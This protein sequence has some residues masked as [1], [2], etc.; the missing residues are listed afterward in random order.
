M[1]HVNMALYEAGDVISDYAL[2]PEEQC[3]FKHSHITMNLEAL[4]VMRPTEQWDATGM[5]IYESDICTSSR[6][7]HDEHGTVGY[8][9]GCPTLFMS[10]GE[11]YLHECPDLRIVGNMYEGLKSDF[12]AKKNDTI[13]KTKKHTNLISEIHKIL[14]VLE[15][16]FD[17]PQL[18]EI[19]A[20]ETGVATLNG[21]KKSIMEVSKV[22]N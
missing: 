12:H 19:L 18:F 8:R 4:K 5:M 9:S 22:E 7:N 11:Y 14:P 3:K 20:K 1:S 17:N 16:I 10:F 21:F 13:S 6:F 2:P 15:R